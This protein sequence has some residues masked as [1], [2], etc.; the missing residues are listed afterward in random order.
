MHLTGR[1]AHMLVAATVVT[2]GCG[3]VRVPGDRLDREHVP[4]A[5]Q[6]VGEQRTSEVVG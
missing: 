3:G 6:Q 2:L 1:L 4:A 5:L